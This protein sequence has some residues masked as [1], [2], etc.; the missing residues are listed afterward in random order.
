MKKFCIFFASQYPSEKR[1]IQ[2]VDLSN[3][4]QM[5]SFVVWIFKPSFSSHQKA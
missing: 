1:E 3:G 2:R 4:P 5:K